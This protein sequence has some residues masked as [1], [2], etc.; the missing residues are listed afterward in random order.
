MIAVIEDVLGDFQESP[1]TNRARSTKAPSL[2]DDQRKFGVSLVGILGS[3]AFPDR[4]KP[5]LAELSEDS[6]LSLQEREAVYR[7]IECRCEE[8]GE[9]GRYE[10]FLIQC[11]RIADASATFGVARNKF[12]PALHKD[13]LRHRAEHCLPPIRKPSES[14]FISLISSHDIYGGKLGLLWMYLESSLQ[15]VMPAS[16]S[17]EEL[18][19]VLV[20][21]QERFLAYTGTVQFFS[22]EKCADR[23]FKVNWVSGGSEKYAHAAQEP[24]LRAFLTAETISRFSEFLADIAPIYLVLERTC[25]STSAESSCVQERGNPMKQILSSASLPPRPEL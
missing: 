13:Y 24:H 8:A 6:K 12:F 16:L 19:K 1:Q 23:F 2:S 3:Y 18:N 10:R 4:E 7:H 20:D 11:A 22:T 5:S 17:V 9:G 15:G 25:F 21:T 14:P